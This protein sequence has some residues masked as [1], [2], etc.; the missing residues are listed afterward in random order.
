MS[1]P[2][3]AVPVCYR[4]TDRETY[5]HCV[6][7]DRPICP[8]CMREAPVGH[9]C[10][11]CVKE[12][13]R[14]VRSITAPYETKK[15]TRPSRGPNP[16]SEALKGNVT[17]LLL[18]LNILAFFLQQGLSGGING[19]GR[20]NQF[21]VNY[22]NIGGAKGIGGLA[23]GEY[24]RLITAAF[25][26]AGLLHI[27]FN[28]F[29]LYQL[30]SVLER[31]LGTWRYLA[32]YAAGAVGGNTLSYI[33]HGATTYSLG[34]ST[35]IFGIFAAFFVIVKRQG[36]DTSQLVALIVINLVLTF[37]VSSIDKFGH[38]G[39]LLVGGLVGLIYT[40]VPRDKPQLQAGMVAGTIVALV[41]LCVL[42]TASLA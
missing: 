36:G 30:G 15:T 4:H 38:V 3:G 9:Q 8:D 41:L 13:A 34:A 22:A 42:K 24:Y 23:D 27:A 12:G 26:H 21:T 7:C 11:E 17:K 29:A 6:R 25:L 5:V 14:A 40:R 1:D 31:L 33:V 16:V 28:M 10:V 20:V 39:G 19:G 35:A 18:G 37:T 2:T 32:L